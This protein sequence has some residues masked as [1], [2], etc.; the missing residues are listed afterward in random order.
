M[1]GI[2]MTENTYDTN[3][4][5]RN[6]FKKL[7]QCE[8]EHEVFVEAFRKFLDLKPEEA[9]DM[10]WKLT[11]APAINILEKIG[12]YA[13]I[14]DEM[15][16]A[17]RNEL[18][19]QY[20]EIVHPDFLKVDVPENCKNAFDV[21]SNKSDIITAAVVYE[22]CQ[23]RMYADEYAMNRLLF[24]LKSDKEN[25]N[26]GGIRSLEFNAD[27]STYLKQFHE[28]IH[29]LLM[30]MYNN[31]QQQNRSFQNNAFEGLD[32]LLEDAGMDLPFRMD[33]IVTEV[34]QAPIEQPEAEQSAQSHNSV[35][36][37]SLTAEE[38]IAHKAVF[39]S[40][41]K[42]ADLNILVNIGQLG[43]DLNEV[44]AKK[45]AISNLLKAAEALGK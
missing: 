44:M 23:Y 20:K 22:R 5:F 16:V 6:K 41:M 35:V 15:F 37:K 36:Y 7:I 24:L 21:L 38:I 32:K 18:R 3:I 28:Q 42:D 31:V 13:C 45:D 11:Y 34:P 14:S 40:F 30:A 25:H 29:D 10:L 39:A 12:L 9:L 1:E 17:L 4:I 26:F 43:F 2:T 19:H 33:D 8:T 27:E